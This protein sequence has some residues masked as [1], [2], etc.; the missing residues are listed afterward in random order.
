MILTI[1]DYNNN[2]KEVVLHDKPIKYITV[3]VITGDECIT[4]TF[5]DGTTQ[6]FDASDKRCRNFHDG[7]YFVEGDRISEFINWKPQGDE[8][9]ISYRRMYDF[10]DEEVW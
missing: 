10:M 8:P 5:D 6:Y 9:I 1:Y 3:Y 7:T 4:V 2:S